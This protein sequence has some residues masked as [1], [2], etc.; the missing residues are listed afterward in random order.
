MLTVVSGFVAGR[1]LN[2]ASHCNGF[3]A[4][5]LVYLFWLCQQK[6]ISK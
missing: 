3:S 1:R 2:Y 5:Y 4:C 6:Y